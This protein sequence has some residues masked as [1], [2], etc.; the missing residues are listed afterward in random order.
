MWY[1]IDFVLGGLGIFGSEWYIHNTSRGS[2]PLNQIWSSILLA[3]L[4]NYFLV[5]RNC[6]GLYY[7]LLWLVMFIFGAYVSY[8]FQSTSFSIPILFCCILKYMVTKKIRIRRQNKD[9]YF[10]KANTML[11][12]LTLLL[13]LL[14]DIQV[15][16]R[17]SI[18]IFSRLF[19]K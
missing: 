16:K 10:I 7:W 6:K 13:L 1:L 15:S 18:L 9:S 19:A 5:W 3:W 12:R 8:S 17:E 2:V 4:L 11:K 14:T